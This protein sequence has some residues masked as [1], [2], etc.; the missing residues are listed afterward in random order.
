MESAPCRMTCLPS[1]N[2]STSV[3]PSDPSSTLCQV[4]INSW[5][6]DLHARCFCDVSVHCSFYVLVATHLYLLCINSL[7]YN[8][9]SLSL[10][11]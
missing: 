5:L 8:L 10:L 7:F 11:K 6:I 2:R 3:S 1:I 9:H 4:L